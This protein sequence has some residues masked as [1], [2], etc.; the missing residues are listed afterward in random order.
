M[1]KQTVPLGESSLERSAGEFAATLPGFHGGRMSA[2]VSVLLELRVRVEWA[3]ATRRDR[4]RLGLAGPLAEL[5]IEI[6]PGPDDDRG[7]RADRPPLLRSRNSANVR[8]GRVL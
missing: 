2:A 3:G 5:Q 6:E 8:D 4:A 7:R 1:V